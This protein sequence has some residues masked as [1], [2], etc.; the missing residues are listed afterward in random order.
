[1]HADTSVTSLR[2]IG[3]KKAAL[4]EKLGI[5]TVR[6][7]LLHQPRSFIDLRFA[8]ELDEISINDGVNHLIKA[9]IIS[10]GREQFIRK[11]FS[12]F[13]VMAESSGIDL[14]IT[15]YNTRYAVQS[16]V[17]DS[18]VYFY[19]PVEGSF[20][21]KEMK[22]PVIIDSSLVGTLYPV[23][24]TTAGLSSKVI[25]SDIRHVLEDGN[26]NIESVISDEDV[27]SLGLISLN[28]AVRKIHLPENHDEAQNARKRLSLEALVTYSTA[29]LSIRGA[30]ETVS[31]EPI[32]AAEIDNF[33]SILPYEPTNAQK[34]SI[35]DILSD[36]SSG[37]IMCRLVQ[38]D[39]GSGKTLVAAAAAYAVCKSGYQTALMAPTE[40]LAEQHLRTLKGF[41]DPLGIRSA[42]LTGAMTA[43]ERR[44]LL[45][46]LSNGEIDLLIGTHA[47]FQDGVKFNSLGLVITDEQHRF[48][49]AQRSALSSKGSS[50]HTLV[51]SATPI[52]RTL[53]LILYGDLDLSLIDEMPAGRQ[54]ISTYV[55]DSAKRSRAINFIKQHLDNGR[56]AYI[57]CPLVEESE[58]IEGLISASKYAE[59][60]SDGI[61]SDYRVGLLHGKM[62][63]KEKD[64][65]MRSFAE[66]EIQLLVSTTVVEVGVDVPN[67]VIML[68]E[69]AERFGLSQLHQLR[70]RVGRGSHESYC[71]LVSDSKNETTKERLSVIRSV[72]DGF[73]IA[74]ED[75][76]LRGPGDLLGLRQHGMPN[77]DLV[78]DPE[79]FIKAQE[80]ALEILKSDPSL[81][82]P[83]H[84]AL[85]NEVD[86]LIDNVGCSVN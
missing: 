3:P 42:L 48:G 66:G 57:V 65:V 27:S 72:S 51:M 62:K 49:V 50:V 86:M 69:N 1:M 41:L 32:N 60:L 53:S 79:L 63:P 76:R 8:D 67:S 77:V 46:E 37:K 16:L 47:L 22:A 23:Y 75:L 59:Q 6:Q 68:I 34:R 7:L 54:P 55:I 12:V 61:F 56:Q 30:R 31:C 26:A 18:E 17:I 40:I 29:M 81:S 33:Y 5:K 74:E 39:V 13:K 64:A 2:G 70:G 35:N 36:L 58:N 83:S 21:H 45:S 4:Y 14:K 44:T 73:K 52:P 10:K 25:A 78:S 85:K 24:P 20:L 82:L 11:G 80:I 71:I 19:G 38:G 43:K 28:D 84:S 9:R 15:F